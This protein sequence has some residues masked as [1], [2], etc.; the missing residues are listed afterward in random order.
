MYILVLLYTRSSKVFQ[1]VS[2]SKLKG[3]GLFL[4]FSITDGVTM[5]TLFVRLLR[6]MYWPRNFSYVYLGIC[7]DVWRMKHFAGKETRFRPGAWLSGLSGQETSQEARQRRA[8]CWTGSLPF[9]QGPCVLRN[10]P[11]LAVL[12]PTRCHQRLCFK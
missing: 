5:K 4:V 6:V 12:H 9:L 1:R 10:G 3:F 11:G 7:S 2:T 8:L